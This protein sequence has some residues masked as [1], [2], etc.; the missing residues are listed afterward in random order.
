VPELLFVNLCDEM[1]LLLDGEQLS[2]AK[3]NRMLNLTILIGGQRK[4]KIPVSCVER[5]R[6]HYHS[7]EF[8]AADSMMY[9]SA[10]AEKMV[11]VSGSLRTYGTRHSD[12]GEVWD[13]IAA[14]ASRLDAHSTTGAAD[15]IYETHRATT[16][17]YRRAFSL[18]RGQI[19][20]LFGIN[21]RM[22]GIEL[23]DSDVTFARTFDKVVTSYAIDAIDVETVQ[24]ASPSADAVKEFLQ[25]L[26]AA[27]VES[28]KAVGEG[29]DLRIESHK[30]VGA[31]LQFE[32]R[33]VH[34]SAFTKTAAAPGWT[35]R[36]CVA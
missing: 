8:A 25:Q 2:G 27:R 6:W 15:A 24:R 13:N 35:D 23:F 10:R 36:R 5:G 20:A 29:H 31:A 26:G 3:Q 4:V 28:F 33:L 1:V 34:L 14:K 16:A 12:Q 18:Q 9:S 19:G 17:E 30:V 21:G 7:R 22:A 32:D 11:A